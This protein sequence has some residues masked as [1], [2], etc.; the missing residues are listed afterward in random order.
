MLDPEVGKYRKR[1][2]AKGQPRSKHK[3]KYE[4]VL[5]ISEYEV[6]NLHTGKQEKHQQKVPTKVC[7]ICGRIDY[8]DSNPL[9]YENEV[10][11]THPI[12]IYSKNL[13]EEAMKLPKWLCSSLGKFA[14]PLEENNDKL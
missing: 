9:Y 12:F 10:V 5:L 2:K 1:S 11:K 6:P 14:T 3:H 8:V 13:S 4:T 7:R